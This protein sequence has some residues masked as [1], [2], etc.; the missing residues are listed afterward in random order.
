MLPKSAC[1]GH[2][3]GVV[4]TAGHEISLMSKNGGFKDNLN[5]HQRSGG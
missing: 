3:G 5:C 2:G 1:V 4:G